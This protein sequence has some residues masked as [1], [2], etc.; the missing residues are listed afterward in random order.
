MTRHATFLLALTLGI[1]AASAQQPAA[2]AAPSVSAKVADTSPQPSSILPGRPDAEPSQAGDLLDPVYESK[3]HGIALRPPKGTKAVHRVGSQNV[4]EFEDASRDWTL[5]VSKIVLPKPG[6]LTETLDAHGVKQPGVLEFTAKRLKEELPAAEIIRQDKISI[7]DADVGMLVLRYTQNLKSLL[8]QQAIIQRNGQ[9]YYLLALTTPGAGKG[10]KDAAA[11]ETERLAFE[12]FRGVLNSVKL[13]DDADVRNDQNARLIRTRGLLVN[14]TSER[15]RQALIPQQWTR[16]LK[17]GKDVGYAYYEEKTIT[18]GAQD[19]IQIRTRSRVVP[20]EDVHNDVGSILNASFDLR[21]EDW[22]TVT[23]TT[24]LKLRASHK[25][26]TPGQVT[27]FGVSDR[28]TVPG[29]GDVFSLQVL[30]EGG[31]TRNDPVVRELPP[32][33]LPEAVSYLL[34][35]MVPMGSDKTYMFA[36]YVSETREVMAR[37]V[38][39]HAPQ[40]VTFNNQVV[41]ATRIDDKIGLEGSVTSN[42]YT[43]DHTWLGSENKTTGITV[44]PSDEKTLMALWKDAILAAPE[45]PEHQP[46]AAGAEPAA[47]AADASQGAQD[48]Q[49]GTNDAKPANGQPIVPRLG[50][51][52]GRR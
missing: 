11:T 20:A 15:L 25:D 49:N 45:A 28:K 29:Q 33:Y 41:R 17:N 31:G 22:S 48:A 13:L 1:P 9:I 10:G 32:F 6:S 14:F 51:K 42:Y 5:K 43:A 23:Q 34:P 36:V 18:K 44:L 39:V 4:V 16:I 40:K 27:E 12:T 19:Y 24:N 46:G 26:Y 3:A 8:T 37:Y 35:R 50:L 47:P 2:P 38:D 7:A 30:Y 52:P 21:H